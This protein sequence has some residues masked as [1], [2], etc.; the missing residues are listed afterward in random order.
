MGAINDFQA[1]INK[2]NG[3]ARPA[4]YEVVLTPPA[5][6]ALAN[7]PKT[8]E[9]QLLCDTIVMPGHDLASSTVKFGTAVATEMVVGHAY[10]GTIEATFYL[11]QQL[12]LKS[13]FDAWQ[14][15]AVDMENNTV[16]YYKNKDGHHNYAGSMKIYQ[17]SSI[18]TTITTITTREDT[19]GGSRDHRTSKHNH[20][21]EEEKINTHESIRTYGIN[22]E[23][24]YP[25]TIGGIS[26]AYATVDTVALLTVSFQYRKWTEIT[27]TTNESTTRTT[28]Q[29]SS[30]DATAIAEGLG[31]SSVAEL[32]S[33]L[34]S[35]V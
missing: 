1:L 18:P 2:S 7:S 21:M 20:G 25:A 34:K 26:Y 22:V 29:S 16:S 23:E 19:S 33:Y 30:L 13:Y 9:I 8:K 35:Q 24:V 5:G 27:D 15:A 10:E 3:F 31:Y 12:D 11:D 6:S 28:R 14:D 32:K 17:L 4:K